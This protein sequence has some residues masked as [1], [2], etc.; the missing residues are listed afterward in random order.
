MSHGWHSLP[1]G[2]SRACKHSSKVGM[3]SPVV[4]TALASV[5]TRGLR[6]ARSRIGVTQAYRYVAHRGHAS[7]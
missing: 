6:Y 2:V 3:N 5:V 1:V 4:G 7:I